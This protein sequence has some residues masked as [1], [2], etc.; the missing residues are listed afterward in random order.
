V[1]AGHT[2]SMKVH[3][4]AV[5]GWIGWVGVSI[6]VVL[7]SL[8]AY[9]GAIENFH[10]GW[11]STSMWENL[12][13]LIFQY[14]LFT[15]VFTG[16]ALVALRWKKIGLALHIAAAGFSVWFFSGASF[17]VVGLMI[18]I[19]IIALGLLYYVGEPQPKKWAYRLLIGIPLAIVLALSIPN[20]IRVSQRMNDRDFGLRIVEGNGVTLAW[21]PR[22]PGWPDKGI[23]WDEAQRMCTYLSEDGTTLMAQEQN[24]WRLPTVDEAVRSMMLHGEKAKGVWNLEQGK[25]VYERTPDKETPLWDVHSKVIYYWTADT[26]AKD[27]RYAYII[28]YHGGVYPKRKTDGQSY[29]S[30]RAVREVGD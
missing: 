10:E 22:G 2:V 13:M 9:W 20:A 3:K 4:K 24:L 29:L 23:S 15:I 28:V 5:A 7:S 27:E 30:F 11:Y 25:A 19:P 21:A 18:V 16:L 12:F 1:D 8:W 14:L 17:S 6:T 26:S